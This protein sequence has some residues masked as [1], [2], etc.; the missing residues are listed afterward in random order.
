MSFASKSASF[1]AYAE[2]IT[3]VAATTTGVATTKA[4][5]EFT[6]TYSSERARLKAL[7]ATPVE[8]QRLLRSAKG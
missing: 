5:S 7:R 4:Y 6:T 8:P 3:I 2:H 1:A